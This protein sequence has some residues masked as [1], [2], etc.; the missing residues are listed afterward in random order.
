MFVEEPDD[1]DDLVS[2]SREY[3]G[4]RTGPFG[5]RGVT[6]IGLQLGQGGV[7]PLIANDRREFLQDRW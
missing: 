7:H 2:G 4:T 6:G 1:G 5:G 3:D